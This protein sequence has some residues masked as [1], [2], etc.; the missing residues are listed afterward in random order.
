M[1]LD[2]DAIFANR[3]SCSSYGERRRI[4][5]ISISTTIG[6]P[7]A[8]MLDAGE[9]LADIAGEFF[10][11]LHGGEVP[12]VIELAPV[13]D[14]VGPFGEPA[15]RPDDFVRERRDPQRDGRRFLATHTV[16]GSRYSRDDE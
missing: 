12:A 8:V 7:P 4:R 14:V 10:G 1:P 3:A 5:E 11:R 9:E 16:D 13:G 15:D 6:P 2:L